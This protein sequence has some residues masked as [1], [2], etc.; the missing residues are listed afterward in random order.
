M[1][2]GWLYFSKTQ[3]GFVLIDWPFASIKSGIIHFTG[4]Q[5]V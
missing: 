5:L 3:L 4:G 1:G 2:F